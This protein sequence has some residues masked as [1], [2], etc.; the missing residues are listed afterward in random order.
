MRL[1][2]YYPTNVLPGFSDLNDPDYE[3]RL[4][5]TAAEFNNLTTDEIIAKLESG[6]E[7]YFDSDWYQ[8]LRDGEIADQRKA[9]IQA[10][11]D[12][13]EKVKCDCGHTVSKVLV[14]RASHGTACSDCYDRMS[15]YE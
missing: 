5:K 13:E 8:L 15:D 2:R 1:Q 14:M 11:R 3:Q 9:R 7:V 6:E 10:A 12:A 4:I